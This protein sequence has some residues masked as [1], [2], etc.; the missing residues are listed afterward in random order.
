IYKSAALFFITKNTKNWNNISVKNSFF[1]PY[2]D[3]HPEDDNQFNVKLSN[4]NIIFLFYGKTFCK[5][6]KNNNSWNIDKY[7]IQFFEVASALSDNLAYAYN[8]NTL[9][10]NSVKNEI[11]IYENINGIEDNE[12]IEPTSTISLY[13]EGLKNNVKTLVINQNKIAGVINEKTQKLFF[14]INNKGKSWNENNYSVYTHKLP[15]NNCQSSIQISLKENTALVNIPGEKLVTYHFK[16]NGEIIEMVDFDIPSEKISNLYGQPTAIGEKNF[17]F[18]SPLSNE[19]GIESGAV[20]YI[21]NDVFTISGISEEIKKGEINIYP[22]PIQNQLTVTLPN[23]RIKNIKIFSIEG[24][25]IYNENCDKYKKTINSEK[26]KKGT[27]II[28]ILSEK[29]NYT[30]KLVK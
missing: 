17:Y 10:I 11:E 12:N 5:Y 25:L 26:L 2:L 19:A 3:I 15:E 20:Y 28:N 22:N 14:I 1:I 6:K 30:F 23:K 9:I 21:N 7:D 18:G 29:D 27:Y 24:K 16:N 4:N 13:K 8:N